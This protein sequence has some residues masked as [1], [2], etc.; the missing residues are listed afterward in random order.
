MGVTINKKVNNNK[1]TLIYILIFQVVLGTVMSHILQ[2]ETKFNV[3]V[4]GD[5]PTG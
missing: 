4:I 2:F 5:V 1:T 3:D